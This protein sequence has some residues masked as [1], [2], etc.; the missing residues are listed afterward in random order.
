MSHQIIIQC[1]KQPDAM[2]RI[3]RTVRHR[4]VVL[5]GMSMICSGCGQQLEL[6]IEVSGSRPLRLLTS[7]LEKLYDVIMWSPEVKQARAENG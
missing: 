2:E 7:Q 6:A 1:R 5:E 4:G 3:L